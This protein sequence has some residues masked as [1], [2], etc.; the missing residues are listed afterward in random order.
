MKTGILGK[1][2][3]YFLYDLNNFSDDENTSLSQ[4]I[5]CYRKDLYKF[6]CI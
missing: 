2:K 4:L 5:I 1:K 6:Y 3:K